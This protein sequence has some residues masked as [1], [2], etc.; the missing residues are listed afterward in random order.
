MSLKD[1]FVDKDIVEYDGKKQ[2]EM[3]VLLVIV[4]DVIN[5]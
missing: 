4:V 2:E 5:H 1:G 3:A